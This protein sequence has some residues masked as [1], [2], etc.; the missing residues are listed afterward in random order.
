MFRR[1]LGDPPAQAVVVLGV[2][3]ALQAL[4]VADVAA[5]DEVGQVLVHG[6]HAVAAAGLQGRVDLMGLAVADQVP[7][8]R[9]GHHDLDPHDPPVPSVV[10]IS[11]WQTTPWRAP[12]SCTRICCCW[13]VGNT[14]IIRST[15][16]GAS[17]V[18]RVANTRW[19]VSA[20]V[21]AI[22]IVSRSRSSPT[23]MMSGSWR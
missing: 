23:R 18:W 9:G 5:A 19:P 14:S 12:A 15:V 17:W 2:V 7:D 1:L 16:W 22:E 13:L 20:A 10:G 11:C 21:R 6:L 4:V 8:R 3:T